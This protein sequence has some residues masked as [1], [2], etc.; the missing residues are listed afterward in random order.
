MRL[1]RK[2]M[3]HFIMLVGSDRARARANVPKVSD[4]ARA[5]AN[6]PIVFTV[7]TKYVTRGLFRVIRAPSVRQVSR[8]KFTDL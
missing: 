8:I 5:R 2:E 4:R 1:R 7:E 3:L 6:V